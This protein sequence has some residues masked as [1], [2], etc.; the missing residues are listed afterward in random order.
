MSGD[1]NPFLPLSFIVGPAIL[2]NACTVLLNGASIRYN[3]AIGLWRD[4]QAEMQGR[5]LTGATP[6]ADRRRALDVADQ[7]AR[8]IVSGLIML[9]AAVGGFGTSAL[10]GLIGAVLSSSHPGAWVEAAKWLTVAAAGAGLVCLLVAAAIFVVES[11]YTVA[12][13]QLGLPRRTGLAV[14][15]TRPRAEDAP[16]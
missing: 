4:L 1:A 2:T 8:L 16:E 12:L 13:L 7:R 6:Y 3:L 5:E 10:T 11:R 9:Y 15:L 14:G